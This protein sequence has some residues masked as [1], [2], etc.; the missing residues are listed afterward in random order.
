MAETEAP[1]KTIDEKL[2]ELEADTLRLNEAI[3]K[4][5]EQNERDKLAGVTYMV[6]QSPVKPKEET[7]IEYKNKI[8]KGSVK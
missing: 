4:K 3:R 8:L 2:E 6:E 5:Q 7:N 1:I